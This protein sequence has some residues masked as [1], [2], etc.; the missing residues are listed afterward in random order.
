MPISIFVTTF[1]LG[2]WLL[3]AQVCYEESKM[4]ILYSEQ[5]CSV[6][7]IILSLISRKR[8]TQLL[9][10]SFTLIGIWLQF[11]CLIFWASSPAT[12]LMHTLIGTSIIALSTLFFPLPNQTPD[13][14]PS[15]PPNWN[16]N[17]SSSAQRMP[18]ALS[19][20]LCWMISRYLSAYQLG[21]IDT[22]WDPFFSPGTQKVLTSTISQLF[23]VSDAGLG[24]FA[25][26][27]EF[28]ATCQGGKARWRTSPWGVLLFGI[29]VIPVS[30]VSI[31]LIISQPLFV[32]SWCT[33]CLITAI[34]M[35]LPIPLAIDEVIASIQYLRNRKGKQFFSLLFRGGDCHQAEID[36]KTPSL[37]APLRSIFK[38]SLWGSS[39]PINL[40]ISALLS[41]FLMSL[42]VLLH[43][44]SSLL[45]IDPIIGAVATV[46]S[47]IS[48]SEHLRPCR[49]INLL[50]AF[51][52][53]IS[54]ILSSEAIL[55]H[56]SM[57]I[58]IALLTLRKGPIYENHS[59]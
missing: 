25:Y 37:D 15:I 51:I 16:Y 6:L 39:F 52:L 44:Q 22:V 1:L 38:A 13:I 11:D 26:T 10:W 4:S 3:T 46:I 35:L 30:I 41:T 47:V 45:T 55:I 32:G 21:Y 36:T 50:L 2:L 24:A 23:P 28:L 49:F 53:M 9:C 31:L 7:L 40:T 42:P 34:L 8:Q 5:I 17:P 29:L 56:L 48:Y 54:S 19:A 33:L 57:A 14:E 43:L 20:F 58:A 12:Y 18:I 59:L 27:L